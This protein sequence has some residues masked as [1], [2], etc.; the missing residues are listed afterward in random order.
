MQPGMMDVRVSIMRKQ[1]TQEPTYGREVITWVPLVAVAGQPTVPVKFS[2]QVSENMPS[3]NEGIRQEAIVD[4][5]KARLRMRYRADIDSSMRVIVHYETDV[6]FEII[7]G[8]A[9]ISG[10][11]SMLELVIERYSS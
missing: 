4:T 2:A 10:R 5:N 7:G 11:K 1:V 3:R 8:P 6:T 9:K